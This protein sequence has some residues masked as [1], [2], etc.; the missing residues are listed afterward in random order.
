MFGYG[1]VNVRL[2][3]TFCKSILSLYVICFT[4]IRLTKTHTYHNSGNTDITTYKYHYIGSQ[5]T[6]IEID[7]IRNPGGEGETILRDEEMLIHL[8]SNSVPISYEWVKHNGESTT[9]STYYFHYDIHG[10]VL[11]ITDSSE[12][13]KISYTYDVLGNISTETNPDSILNLF[14]FRGASQTIWEPETNL[15]YSGGYYRP[16]TGTALQGTGAPVLTNPSSGSIIESV[17]EETNASAQ[18]D[19]QAAVSIITGGSASGGE[20]GGFAPPSGPADGI[21]H[22]GRTRSTQTAQPSTAPPLDVTTAGTNN[23]R[24]LPADH[25]FLDRYLKQKAYEDNLKSMFPGSNQ[26]S[27]MDPS[28]G[29]GSASIAELNPV[30]SEVSTSQAQSAPATDSGGGVSAGEDVTNGV[31]G[32]NMNRENVPDSWKKGN[33]QAK[34]AV[35]SSKDGGGISLMFI[36]PEVWDFIFAALKEIGK[37]IFAFIVTYL[38]TEGLSSKK[39]KVYAGIIGNFAKTLPISY[40]KYLAHRNSHRPGIHGLSGAEKLMDAALKTGK[41]LRRDGYKLSQGAREIFWLQH[42]EQAG[43]V[44]KADYDSLTGD[45]IFDLI[46]TL[47]MADYD[48]INGPG[49]ADK[50]P[51]GFENW[52]RKSVWMNYLVPPQVGPP[53]P[54][55]VDPGDYPIEIL[56]YPYPIIPPPPE[57]TTFFEKKNN[58]NEKV[59]V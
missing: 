57:S 46:I 32:Y 45:E 50:D 55:N 40:Q 18:L 11:K 41:R 22:A 5:M 8:G 47:A 31:V 27:F 16:D 13:I 43:D 56:P 24:L 54:G 49:A 37:W 1:D 38:L 12:N 6:E 58:Y 28:S 10:N 52:L 19:T 34:A 2:K 4:K 3:T 26:N 36:P 53:K 48:S 39:A 20:P 44:S 15:Y 51:I 42:G 21:T 17:A 30:Q 35:D 7:S 29:A 33:N 9:Q 14:T 25:E 23:S 59:Q